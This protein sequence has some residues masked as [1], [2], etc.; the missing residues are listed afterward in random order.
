MN[1]LLV[2]ICLVWFC[3]PLDIPLSP[4]FAFYCSCL[5]YCGIFSCPALL[6]FQFLL[7]LWGQNQVW[8]GTFT[9]NVG[10]L[11]PGDPGETLGA[12][13]MWPQAL[14]LVLQGCSFPDVAPCCPEH[15]DSWAAVRVTANWLHEH[16]LVE[17]CCRHVPEWQ[18]LITSVHRMHFMPLL[19][20][21]P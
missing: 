9:W 8:G 21:T 20:I 13:S 15:L 10:P 16:A 12:G 1:R 7:A 19:S 14:R 2:W 3:F 4:S 11:V 18:L 17:S 5:L 6:P